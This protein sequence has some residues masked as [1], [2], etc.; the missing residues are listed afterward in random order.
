MTT[1]YINLR[2][3]DG[4]TIGIRCD[5]GLIRAIGP[6]VTGPDAVDGEGRL[7]LPAF[8]EPHVHLDK[9]LW[10]EAW[11]PGHRAAK[12]RDYIDNERR[13]LSANQTAPEDRAARLLT[14]M[15]RHGTT[16]VRSH[17]DIAPDMGL[18]HVEA[19]MRLREAWR[20]RV[21]L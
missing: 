13:V 8:V 7:V 15:L 10:G 3:M 11:Q 20:D 17:I 21:D 12:L 1:T 2:D 14:E 16:A 18:A 6:D 5:D 9:T 19:M 4:R